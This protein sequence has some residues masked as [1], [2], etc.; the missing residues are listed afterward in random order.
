[1]VITFLTF[2]PGLAVAASPATC[3]PPENPIK[4]TGL[5]A[6]I[7]LIASYSALITS[8]AKRAV[9]QC[10]LEQIGLLTYWHGLAS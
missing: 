9:V 1:M 8:G 10:L 2:N 6:T 7:F 4:I 5:L 3:A